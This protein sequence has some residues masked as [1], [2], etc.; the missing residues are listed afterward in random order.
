MI[1]LSYFVEV[2]T[3]KSK[4]Q[5]DY[6]LVTSKPHD[7]DKAQGYWRLFPQKNGKTLAA[8]VAFVKVPMGVVNLLPER[9]QRKINRGLLACPRHLRTW[10]HGEA[11]ARYAAVR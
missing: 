5:I 4:W 3:D 8:Y 9:L 10:I 2:K 1:G 6:K 11:G 7:I